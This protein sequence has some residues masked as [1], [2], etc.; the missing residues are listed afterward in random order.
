MINYCG[1]IKF[2]IK[3]VNCNRPVVLKIPDQKIIASIISNVF[4]IGIKAITGNDIKRGNR[5]ISDAR[6]TLIYFL[7]LH[8]GMTKKAIGVFCGRDHSSV[9]YAERN[10]NRLMVNRE[11]NKKY[12]DCDQLIKEYIHQK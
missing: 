8:T 3:V 12:L 2:Q 4:E 9:I 11:Y 10:V 7:L 6:H 5:N 1:E